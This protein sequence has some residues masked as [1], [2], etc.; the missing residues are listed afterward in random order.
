MG[1]SHTMT[2]NYLEGDATD[3]VGH[4]SKI[5]VHICNDIGKWGK[6]FVVAISKRWKA[7]EQKYKN[8]FNEEVRPK[9]GDVQFVPVNSTITVANIIGQH[10]VKTHRSKLLMPPIR[11]EAVEKGL[12]QV[13]DYAIDNNA[14]VHM[15]KIGCGLAGGSWLKIEPIICKTLIENNIPVT[16][17]EL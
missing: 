3:P 17:Y 2:V 15:P 7:P 14:T 6:G 11:Y 12:T 4:G 10:G 1:K 8:S 5:I 13:A 9:L 16:V